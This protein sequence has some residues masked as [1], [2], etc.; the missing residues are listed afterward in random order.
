MSSKLDYCNSFLYG[1]PKY[2]M[3]KLQRVLNCAARVVACVGRRKHITPTL[4]ALH[5]L[6]IDER[7][8]FKILLLTFKALHGL[9]PDY[10]ASLL[11]VYTPTRSLRSTNSS[12]LVIPPARLKTYGERAFVYSAPKLWNRMPFELKSETDLISFKKQL[13][14]FLF[15]RAYCL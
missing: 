13:K 6:P 1:I 8:E 14:T 7:I 5:W 9:A 3:D 12:S 10:L 11:Q 2:Q 15:K 4:I